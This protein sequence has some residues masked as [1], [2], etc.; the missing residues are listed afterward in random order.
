MNHFSQQLNMSHISQC[1]P[2][3]RFIGASTWGMGLSPKKAKKTPIP[4][5]QRHIW[6]PHRYLAVVAIFR[7]EAQRLA[8]WIEFQRLLGVEHIYLYDNGRSDDP[9]KVLAPYLDEGFVTLIP[10]AFPWYMGSVAAQTLAYAHALSS[11]GQSW[12]W[13]AF[14]DVDEFLFPVVD[15]TLS[16]SLLSYEDLPAVSVFWVMFGFSGHKT[17]PVGGVIEN[18]V[19]RA[20]FPTHTKVKCIVNPAEVI[21]VD[22]AHL[23]NLKIGPKMAFTESRKLFDQSWEPKEDD[24]GSVFRLNHYYTLSRAEFAAKC[25][26]GAEFQREVQHDRPMPIPL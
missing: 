7:D 23:F 12:R 26:R 3:G 1:K 10:W 8:E 17:P 16:E 24:I 2:L 13:V 5:P 21:A 11:F 15:M 4:L 25:E 22:G 19:M 18:Y 6:S 14:I 9:Q 20:P